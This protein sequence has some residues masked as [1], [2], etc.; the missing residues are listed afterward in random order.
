MTVQIVEGPGYRLS[1]EGIVLLGEWGRDVPIEC[2]ICG[3]V[4]QLRLCADE[5]LSTK[6]CNKH[7]DEYLRNR[8]W[9]PAFLPG[10]TC[11]D[12]TAVPV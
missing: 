7:M 3:T 10:D 2:R 5:V 1:S 4:L 12:C 6:E 8:G 11:P 9:T